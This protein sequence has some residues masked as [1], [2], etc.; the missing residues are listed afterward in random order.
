MVRSSSLDVPSPHACIL[1]SSLGTSANTQLSVLPQALPDAD[2]STQRELT[3]LVVES[4]AVSKKQKLRL[5]VP[6]FPTLL[7]RCAP[8]LPVAP[9]FCADNTCGPSAQRELGLSTAI[10]L[11]RAGGVADELPVAMNE[12][13][14]LDDTTKVQVLTREGYLQLF[15]AKPATA[16]VFELRSD[17]KICTSAFGPEK[18]A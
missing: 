15:M 4:E 6:D 7:T 3:L 8:F 17:E 2:A 14:D 9:A 13:S 10:V 5:T 11:C 16:V 18:G 12:L 1:P